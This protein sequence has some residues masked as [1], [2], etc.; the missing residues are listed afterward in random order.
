MAQV[1]QIPSKGPYIQYVLY[2]QHTAWAIVLLIQFYHRVLVSALGEGGIMNISCVIQVFNFFVFTGGVLV[3]MAFHSTIDERGHICFFGNK[4]FGTLQEIWRN[5]LDEGL[6]T[7]V[8]IPNT[9]WVNI[10]LAQN[11]RWIIHLLLWSLLLLLLL[12]VVI[13][14]IISYCCYCYHY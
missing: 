10:R 2:N 9:C 5:M 4:T 6:I 13:V 12:L 7:A 1:V 11:F 8:I 14:N 3:I